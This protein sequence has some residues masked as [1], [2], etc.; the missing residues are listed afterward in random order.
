[1]AV[2]IKRRTPM[3]FAICFNCGNEKQGAFNQCPSCGM[4]PKEL[5]RNYIKRKD[6]I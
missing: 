6:E 2:H 3:T 4:P 1:L 5:T